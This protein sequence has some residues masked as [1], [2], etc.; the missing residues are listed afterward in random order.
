MRGRKLVVTSP[1]ARDGLSYDFGMDL[2]CRNC[3]VKNGGPPRRLAHTSE[4]LGH[5]DRDF[6]DIAYCYVPPPDRDI[7][8]LL[9]ELDRGALSLQQ[10]LPW[11]KEQEARIRADAPAPRPQPGLPPHLQGWSQFAEC[12]ASAADSADRIRKTDPRPALVRARAILILSR[13]LDAS[14]HGLSFLPAL[15]AL[16]Q[17]E[18]CWF[19]AIE[20]LD[21]MALAHLRI[22]KA[23]EERPRMREGHFAT[24]RFLVEALIDDKRYDEALERSLEMFALAVQAQDEEIKRET[25][26]TRGKIYR[27][28]GDTERRATASTPPASS[29]RWRSAGAGS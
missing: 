6:R 17:K 10:L 22:A 28:L 4:L 1:G 29:P 21:R 27:S 23:K 14:L 13:L 24:L 15:S 5:L 2:I 11:V 3:F 25:R 19:E 7:G 8:G 16:F 20:V 12:L 9:D 18:E 26:T